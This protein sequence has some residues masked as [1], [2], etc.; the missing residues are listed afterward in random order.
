MASRQEAS[1]V[2]V[3]PSIFSPKIKAEVDRRGLNQDKN[4]TGRK[5]KDKKDSFMHDLLS[6]RL[7]NP[8]TFEKKAF[9][10]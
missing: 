8:S 5:K 4:K 7:N 3:R 1:T 9:G 2:K 10:S 6:F